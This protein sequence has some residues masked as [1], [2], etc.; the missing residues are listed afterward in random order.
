MGVGVGGSG[1][2]TAGRLVLPEVTIDVDA[3]DPAE[4]VSDVLVDA[5]VLAVVVSCI[6]VSCIS[7][8]DAG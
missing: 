6:V 2:E 1:Q 3:S 7:A 5:G 4:E 8:V